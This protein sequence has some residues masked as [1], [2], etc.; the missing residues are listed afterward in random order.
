MAW[1]M[2]YSLEEKAILRKMDRGN[3]CRKQC[4]RIL[5]A[6]RDREPTLGYL[7]S[8]ILKTIIL[9][10]GTT[11]SWDQKDLARRVLDMLDKLADALE[12]G[13]LTHY[14]EMNILSGFSNVTSMKQSAERLRELLRSEAKFCRLID[15]TKC[16]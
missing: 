9:K 7:H 12:A 10:N 2:S 14:P 4:L 15:P 6:I 1:R 8:F 3:G 16:D 5:K 11:T 13:N